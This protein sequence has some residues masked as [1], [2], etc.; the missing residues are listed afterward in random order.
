MHEPAGDEPAANVPSD[1]FGRALHRMTLVVA[2]A[3]GMRLFAMIALS[4][5]SVAGRWLFDA[6]V[7]GD[8]ELV[9]LGCAICVAAMLPWRQMERGH[10]IVD[11]FT[12][13][14][15]ARTRIWL[16]AFGALAAGGRRRAYR[17]APGAARSG[18]VN[19]RET[20]ETT[21][22]LAVPVWYGYAPMVPA[23]A[24]LTVTGCYTAGQHRSG[25]RAP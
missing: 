3:G 5:W 14:A 2:I 12:L 18:P 21:M 17:L 23:F 22:I 15:A 8:F 4:V 25:I 11:F 13:R 1:A 19:G 24:L 10:V 6:P 7:Q 9:Q 20:Q 16:D